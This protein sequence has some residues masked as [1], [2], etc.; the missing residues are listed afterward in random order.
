MFERLKVSYSTFIS[1]NGVNLQDYS[2]AKDRQRRTNVKLPSNYLFE[3]IVSFT[4]LVSINVPISFQ[5][6]IS[7]LEKDKRMVVVVEDMESLH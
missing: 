4:L 5:E 1:R 3:D 2:L 6:V 7:S